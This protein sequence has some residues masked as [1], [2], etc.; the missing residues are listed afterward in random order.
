MFYSIENFKFYCQDSNQEI[1]TPKTVEIKPKTVLFF[2]FVT[3]NDDNLDLSL[4][5]YHQVKD[6][7]RPS[8]V[9]SSTGS[10]YNTVQ[11]VVNYQ[12]QN[13]A[14]YAVVDKSKKKR[15]TVHG[16]DTETRQQTHEHLYSKVDKKPGGDNRRK[17]THS[18]E[19]SETVYDNQKFLSYQAQGARPKEFASSSHSNR[20]QGA[21]PKEFASSPNNRDGNKRK[22]GHKRSRSKG[23][24]SDFAAESVLR[25]NRESNSHSLPRYNNNVVSSLIN[26][27]DRVNSNSTPVI[28]NRNDGLVPHGTVAPGYQTIGGV[29][30]SNDV[31]DDPDYDTVEEQKS[32]Y[33]SDHDPNYES[34][35]GSATAMVMS[36]TAAV[37]RQQ[38]VSIAT[39]AAMATS[40]TNAN[41]QSTVATAQ[42][43]NMNPDGSTEINEVQVNSAPHNNARTWVR[44]EHIYQEIQDAKNENIYTPD[45]TQPHPR[46]IH[47]SL[48]TGTHNSGAS[49]ESGN[50]HRPQQFVTNL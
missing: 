10:N 27:A 44:R 26:N 23:T 18:K 30:C 11:D 6:V 4:G 31:I 17:E 15:Q 13:M 25:N 1:F 50:S 19:K 20:D 35:P 34:L 24:G 41:Q 37:N 5:G 40:T 14:E 7:K 46:R 21:R 29:A 28:V 36:R 22:S 32:V 8:S 38:H 43:I 49:G 33:T 39:A 47:N 3:D 12:Q 16:I 42:Q 45:P 9:C 48:M 2:Y